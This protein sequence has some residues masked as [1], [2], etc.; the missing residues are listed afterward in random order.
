MSLCCP[1]NV[2]CFIEVFVNS[3]VFCH[4]FGELPDKFIC[5]YERRVHYLFHI[6]N[7]NLLWLCKVVEGS[8]NIHIS[9]RCQ[10]TYLTNILNDFQST[11]MCILNTEFFLPTTKNVKK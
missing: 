5:L 8:A 11:Q 10:T 4:V 6:V 7:N 1:V 3:R 9:I 2:M